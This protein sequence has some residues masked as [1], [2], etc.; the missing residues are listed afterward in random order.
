MKN[1]SSKKLEN[2]NKLQRLKNF[3]KEKKNIIKKL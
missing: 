2:L 1:H 3:R